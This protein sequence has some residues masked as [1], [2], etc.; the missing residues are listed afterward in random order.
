MNP[1]ADGLF[2]RYWLQRTRAIAS[3]PERAGVAIGATPKTEPRCPTFQPR[4]RSSI[5]IVHVQIPPREPA[6]P[7]AP[8]RRCAHPDCIAVLR[9]TNPGPCCEQCK[10]TAFAAELALRGERAAA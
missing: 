6:G 9:T 4:R 5:G 7:Y 2:S 1:S 3:A 8:G 10:L